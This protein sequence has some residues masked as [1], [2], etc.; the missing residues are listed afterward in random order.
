MDGVD[1]DDENSLFSLALMKAF[2]NFMV[3]HGLKLSAKG[4]KV[5]LFNEL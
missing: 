4:F 2:S 1:I 3:S 5:L